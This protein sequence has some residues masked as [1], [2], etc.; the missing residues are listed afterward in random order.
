MARRNRLTRQLTD[1][2]LLAPYVA[3]RR[4]MGLVG[5][6][7]DRAAASLARMGM[8]KAVAFQQSGLEAAFAFAALP[9]QI[10]KPFW[11]DPTLL[12]QTARTNTAIAEAWLEAVAKSVAPVHRRVRSNA[13]VRKR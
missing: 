7:P 4:S 8:E 3:A 9:W 13:R 6:R 10:A 5:S 2:A 12:T 11:L 1:L